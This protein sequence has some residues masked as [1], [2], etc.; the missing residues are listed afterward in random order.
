L[1]HP[2]HDE[3]LQPANLPYRRFRLVGADGGLIK[4]SLLSDSALVPLR[5]VNSSLVPTAFETPAGTGA[6]QA[7]GAVVPVQVTPVS[8]DSAVPLIYKVYVRACASADD[9]VRFSGA[10]QANVL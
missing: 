10:F 3:D 2:D 8:G 6:V 9:V 7:K 1:A 5:A 4:G